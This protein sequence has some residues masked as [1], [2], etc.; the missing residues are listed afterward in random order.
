MKFL[1]QRVKSANVKVDENVIG[2]INNGLM[3]LVGITESDNKEIADYLINKLVNM[4]IFED[5]NKKMNRSLLDVKGELLIVSQ[6]TLYAD[7]SSGNRP[8]FTNAARPEQAK[9]LYNYIINKC[10][11]QINIVEQG[12]FG[13]KMQVE[14]I[15]D[16]PV[17]IMLEK[18]NNDKV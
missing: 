11:E 2:K 14:L 9:Q 4:R 13:A 17:T 7:C 1:I 3:V 16:G 8:S 15:N 10:K 6:F 18:Q 5:D 12:E